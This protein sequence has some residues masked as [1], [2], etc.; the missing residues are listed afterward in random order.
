MN[1]DILVGTSGRRYRELNIG[2]SPDI[3]G[4]MATLANAKLANRFLI[5][6]GNTLAGKIACYSG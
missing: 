3:S 5:S 2:D 1:R 4:R 6:A